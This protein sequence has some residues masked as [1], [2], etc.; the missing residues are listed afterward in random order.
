MADKDEEILQLQKI[1]AEQS[2]AQ[3]LRDELVKEYARIRANYDKLNADIEA[4]TKSKKGKNNGF[5]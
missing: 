3:L 2:M 5:R 1:I 4:I